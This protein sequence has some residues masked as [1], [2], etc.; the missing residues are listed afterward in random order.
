MTNLMR[1]HGRNNVTDK[2]M[3]YFYD[4]H[5]NQIQLVEVLDQ[6]IYE[7]IIVSIIKTDYI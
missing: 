2:K 1:F 4:M 5:K 3:C 7:H 6:N